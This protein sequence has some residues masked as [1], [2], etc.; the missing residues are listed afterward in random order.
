MTQE[1]TE[2]PRGLL[3]GPRVQAE[4]E[5]SLAVQCLAVVLWGLWSARLLGAQTRLANRLW[6]PR[7]SGWG[8]SWG[9]GPLLGAGAVEAPRRLGKVSRL[10][11][12]PWQAFYV[13]TWWEQRPFRVRSRSELPTPLCC[14][15]PGPLQLLSGSCPRFAASLA[16]LGPPAH[17]GWLLP[18]PSV[19]GLGLPSCLGAPIAAITLFLPRLGS[20]GRVTARLL[21]SDRR[22]IIWCVWPLRDALASI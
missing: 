21:H 16:G 5:S 9:L 7:S 17:G 10:L 6:P 1:D 2:A 3:T 14:A 8:R 22:A 11:P 15:S 12:R 13:G 18:A 19:E 4:W 20:A